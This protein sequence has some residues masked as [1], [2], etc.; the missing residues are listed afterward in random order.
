MPAIRAFRSILIAWH[1][2]SPARTSPGHL[3]EGFADA[4]PLDTLGRVPGSSPFPQERDQPWPAQLTAW[5]RA[6][7][8]PLFVLA[9]LFL[10]A[11]AAPILYP[12]LPEWVDPLSDLVNGAVWLLFAVDY[13]VRLLLVGRG[14]RWRFVYTHPLDLVMVIIPL[15]RPLRLVLCS[16]RR[17]AGTHGPRFEL[18]RACTSPA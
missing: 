11:Y 4:E 17:S 15:A 6:T 18:G 9:V 1:A 14:R 7:N 10:V 16:S 2:G 8:T 5:E 3:D 12:Q 13:A